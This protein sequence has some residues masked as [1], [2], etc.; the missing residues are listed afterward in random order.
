MKTLLSVMLAMTT[1]LTA[2]AQDKPMTSTYK[3]DSSASP[4]KWVG[5]KI[6]GEHSGNVTVK[7]GTLT[8]TGDVLTSGEV[9]VDMNSLTVTD[10]PAKDEMNGKLTGHLK[11][12]DFFNVAKYPDAKLVITGSEKTKTGLKVKGNLTFIGKTN[13]IEF[14]AVVNKSNSQVTAKSDVKIDRTKWDLKYGSGSFFKGLGDK[15]INNDFL[16]S[17][18]LTAKK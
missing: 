4:V 7:D 18:D 15:A 6:T 17:V 2:V 13:P 10:I 5:K 12:P 3:V 9:N 11:S 1:T 8:F 14:D 16:L